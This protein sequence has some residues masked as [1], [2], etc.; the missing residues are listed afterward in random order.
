[1]I[2]TREPKNPAIVAK[3][4]AL[5]EA[6]QRK[7]AKENGN[8]LTRK[9]LIGAIKNEIY[10]MNKGFDDVGVRPIDRLTNNF[11][12]F[13]WQSFEY[14]FSVY[15]KN[16]DVHYGDYWKFVM[17]KKLVDTNCKVVKQLRKRFVDDYARHFF[18]ELTI[19]QPDGTT[20]TTTPSNYLTRSEYNGYCKQQCA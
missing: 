13:R 12:H 15:L 10:L 4:K 8:I 6:E 11:D 5:K 20:F 2:L 9:Q 18:G 16:A 3:I 17:A 14:G 19:L 7:K 1:M